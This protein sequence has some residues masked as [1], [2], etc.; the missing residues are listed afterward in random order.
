MLGSIGV[1]AHTLLAVLFWTDSNLIP[2]GMTGN[3]EYFS[4]IRVSGLREPAAST[5]SRHL[6]S[7]FLNLKD[8]LSESAPV[9]SQPQ[10]GTPGSQGSAQSGREGRMVLAPE[11]AHFP[12]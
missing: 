4:R 12:N 5:T 11:A 7:Q 6:G 10:G 1:F 3:T 8:I 2:A 9:A